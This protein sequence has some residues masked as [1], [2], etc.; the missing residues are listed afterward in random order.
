MW[1]R[2]LADG[3]GRMVQWVAQR[4]PLSLTVSAK[5]DK[6]VRAVGSYCLWRGFR[7]AISTVRGARSCSFSCA[8]DIIRDRSEEFANEL[9]RGARWSPGEG[10]RNEVACESAITNRARRRLTRTVVG[11]SNGR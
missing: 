8:M 7:E 10:L 5:I 1:L 2:R 11:A 3:E 9:G 4:G 6:W